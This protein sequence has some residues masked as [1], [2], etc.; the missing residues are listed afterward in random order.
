MGQVRQMPEFGTQY[1]EARQVHVSHVEEPD[2]ENDP[3]GQVRM[4]L[5]EHD[6]PDGHKMHVGEDEVQYRPESHAHSMHAV[7][8]IVLE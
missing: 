4:E 7:D 5:L 1:C 8:P 3:A 2:K 6:E